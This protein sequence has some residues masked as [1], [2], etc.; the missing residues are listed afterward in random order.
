[1][2]AGASSIQ[3]LGDLNRAV[4]GTVAT[5]P[6]PV[7]GRWV[8]SFSDAGFNARTW[9]TDGTN[10]GTYP[11]PGSSLSGLYV[12]FNGAVYYAGM[13]ADAGT[14]R[15]WKSDGTVAGTSALPTDA[16]GKITTQLVVT[17]SHIYFLT[18]DYA[19]WRTDGTS[20]GTMKLADF[21]YSS[22]LVAF[23]DKV[24]LVASGG[25]TGTE[26]W[27]SDGTP[28]GTHVL[29]DIV[30]G[31]GGSDPS[32][33][34]VAGARGYFMARPT[35]SADQV[36]WTTDGTDAGTVQVGA[37]FTGSAAYAAIAFQGNAHLFVQSPNG[38]YRLIRTDGTA[39]GT[40]ALAS[41]INPYRPPAVT[42]AGFFFPTTVGMTAM[43]HSDGTIAGTGPIASGAFLGDNLLVYQDHVYLSANLAQAPYNSVLKI[44]A[45]APFSITD[46]GLAGIPYAALGSL[47]LT[48]DVYVRASDGSAANSRSLEAHAGIGRISSQCGHSPA[49]LN[50]VALFF[51]DDADHGC[52]LW[53]SDGTPAGTTLV[54][55]IVPGTDGLTF[56]QASATPIVVAGGHAFFYTAL[57]GLWATDGTSGGTVKLHDFPAP[58]GL[59]AAG[60]FGYFLD[61]AFALWKSDGTVAG[62]T[63][64]TTFGPTQIPYS[65]GYSA[66]PDTLVSVGSKLF[67]IGTNASLPSTAIFR[68]DGT[69]GGTAPLTYFPAVALYATASRLY[70]V[71]YDGSQRSLWQVDPVSGSA[72]LVKAVSALN[73]QI[74]PSLGTLGDTLFVS[75]SD[76]SNGAWQ[77]GL[78][79]VEGTSLERLADW[80]ESHGAAADGYFYFASSGALYRTDGTAAATSQLALLGNQPD[81]MTSAFGSVF[82]TGRTSESGTE[83]WIANR[84]GAG[85][86]QDYVPGPSSLYVGVGVHPFAVLPGGL[87]FHAGSD[88]ASEEPVFY[89]F[90]QAPDVLPFPAAGP[91]APGTT[92]TS[93]PTRAVGF[94]IPMPASVIGAS[95]CLSS[96]PSCTCDR[97]MIGTQLT[98]APG[99]YVCMREVSSLAPGGIASG[100]LRM[101]GV[102][103][104]FVA[105]TGGLQTLTVQRAGA[106]SG[107]VRSTA[108]GIDCG[109]ACLESV[110]FGSSVTIRAYAARGSVFTGWG[111]DCSGY[112]ECSLTLD[113]SKTAIANFEKAARSS[114]LPDLDG[115]GKAD[116]L[117]THPD[118][119]TNGAWLMDG[120]G[121]RAR[122]IISPP[123]DRATIAMT[124]DFDGDGRTDI[125]WTLPGGGF[126]LTLMDGLAVRASAKLLDCCNDWALVGKGDFNGDGRTDL[127]LRHSSGLHGIWLMNG[128][129]I[130]Q[131]SLVTLPADDARATLFADFDG[132]GRT[133]IL[134]RRVDGT[135]DV[136]LMS[137]TTARVTRTVLDA[138]SGWS[139][140]FTADLDG[141]GKA[142]LIWSSVYGNQGAWLMD[143]LE[144]MRAAELIGPNTGWRVH[145]VADLDGDG[146][147]DLIWTDDHGSLG[148]WLMDGTTRRSAASWLGPF[149]GW[150]VRAVDDLDG[151]GKQ[152]LLLWNQGSGEVG[153]WLMDGLAIRRAT[154]ILPGGTGWLVAPSGIN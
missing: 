130:Q 127:V 132:D 152:D 143:G 81:N 73:G 46:T 111:G 5:S 72:A 102:D 114:G 47:L 56:G 115:D 97:A 1:M 54:K 145:A 150:S 138:H 69:P 7:N 87:V 57:H 28:S 79:A 113:G 20:A 86:V 68:S 74:S 124:G 83:L 17:P 146:K 51:A 12:A 10:E 82:F 3:P 67:I 120:G 40:F 29:K 58:S 39:A 15:L 52:E 141:D 98:I 99:D 64:V 6:A 147:S 71:S 108:P 90:D 53:R 2:L 93:A 76:F 24:L 100:I 134:W 140:V 59:V 128:T 112:T 8:L 62:T 94:D 92:V 21:G 95:A 70:A 91:L 32:G 129:A 88:P 66:I 23:G 133:D 33:L 153:T 14:T 103:S 11:L 43:W 148:G 119:F 48:S 22:G 126:W 63:Q 26:V 121:F 60:D 75:I 25:A 139:P 154:L 101:G 131:A 13:D 136:S 49:T 38:T 106:G 35:A 142:D 116:I 44:E 50:D 122:G 109:L 78:Y 144:V 45:A 151:D 16:D 110:A 65:P 107:V 19:L 89:D 84:A 27:I 31:N 104:A 137:G 135:I 117:W 96:T 77:S 55:D 9:A 123:V 80:S 149:T 61:N 34:G 105:T 18:T 42:S 125:V 37:S 30:P 85:M 36:L 118:S 41:G 4:S